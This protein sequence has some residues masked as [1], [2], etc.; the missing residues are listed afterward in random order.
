MAQWQSVGWQP[1]QEQH[2]PPSHG[3]DV[4]A[5]IKFGMPQHEH[6]PGISRSNLAGLAL[7]RRPLAANLAA[8]LPNLMWGG[9]IRCRLASK[10]LHRRIPSKLG[11]L[12][13]EFKQIKKSI[14]KDYK[15]YKE[16]IYSDRPIGEE[17][18]GSKSGAAGRP[19]PVHEVSQRC[20]AFAAASGLP[21]A[22]HSAPRRGTP[23]LSKPVARLVAAV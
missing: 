16:L 14:Q 22:E 7:T 20:D 13:P 1:D 10:L 4:L 17:L 9:K 15:D 12:R 18:R 2:C 11:L 6:P 3:L 21:Q 5:P 8:S 23:V 19:P